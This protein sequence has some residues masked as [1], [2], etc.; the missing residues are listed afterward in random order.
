ME[1]RDRHERAVHFRAAHPSRIVGSRLQHPLHLV[2]GVKIEFARGVEGREI[3]I[4]RFGDSAA[5]ARQIGPRA[6]EQRERIRIVQQRQQKMLKRN[7]A[8]RA[9][10]GSRNGSLNRVGEID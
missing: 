7:V 6:F 1:Q 8:M 10:L 3:M 5:K 9:L 4:Y 2:A